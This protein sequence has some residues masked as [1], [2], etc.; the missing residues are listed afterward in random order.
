MSIE[1]VDHSTA[2]Q[3][4][5]APAGSAS[6]LP[7]DRG[8]TDRGY[9]SLIITQFFG[10]MNDNVLK[11]VL[12]FMVI[13]GVWSG[14][15]GDGGQGW[16]GVCFTLPFILLSGYAGQISDR[17]SKSDVTWWVKACEIPI[18]AVAGLGF[19]IGN[20]WITLAALV[21][22]TIQSSFFGPAKYGMIPELVDDRLLSKANGTINMATN[23]AVI[24]GTLIAGV[25][26]DRYNPI[27]D[28]VAPLRWLPMVVLVATAVAGFVSASM[29][30]KLAEIGRR[31]AF[32][33]NPFST[34]IKTIREMSRTPLLMVMMA[35]GYFYFMVGIALFILPEYSDVLSISRTE[36]SVLMGV[37]G[38]AVG[39]GCAAA[40][41]ISGD[42]IRPRLVPIGAAGLVLFF[43]LLGLVPP[44]LGPGG[45]MVRVA[46][47]SAAWFV[48][49]AGISAGFYIVP[50]QALLQK[51]SPDD[52]RGRYLGT[53]NGVSF[54]F[55]TVSAV[56]YT[57]IRNPFGDAPQRI[58]VVCGILMAVGSAFFL[59]RLKNQS[60]DAVD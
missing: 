40:G 19:L 13:N 12:T 38:V 18:A 16:V 42:Q 11:T 58:F 4:P 37:M 25:V 44:T 43:L 24:V 22:L 52:E 21:A 48:V 28:A 23:L 1:S 27:D 56:V 14:Q 59:W 39:V 51:L 50:L 29:M 10:A 9:V 17:Y 35:W 2:R 5:T 41:W 53:A 36:A 26:A 30:P 15:L 6:A 47:G 8:L 57:M 32:D 7:V 45:N 55:M 60:L 3:P 31:E 54:L 33:Y 20:L 34:Y 49:G 46:T